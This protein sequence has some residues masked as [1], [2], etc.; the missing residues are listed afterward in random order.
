MSR[1]WVTVLMLAPLLALLPSEHVTMPEDAYHVAGPPEALGEAEARVLEIVDDG[2]ALRSLAAPRRTDN[3]VRAARCAADAL[4]TDPDGAPVGEVVR[5]CLEHSGVTD[6]T[7]WPFTLRSG[8]EGPALRDLRHL[9]RNHVI[10]RPVSHVGVG[11]SEETDSRGQRLLVLVFVQRR[12]VLD[13]F[14]RA[15]RWGQSLAL[16]GHLPPDSGFPRVL[17]GRTVGPGL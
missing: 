12:V 13:P 8:P 17:V 1:T 3:L 5:A 10:G 2:F 14:P 7:T 9:V 6:V 4:V 16:S 15:A 11:S